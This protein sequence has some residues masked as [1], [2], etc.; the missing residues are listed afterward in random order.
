MD[1]NITVIVICCIV[2]KTAGIIPLMERAL[3]TSEAKNHI[4]WEMPTVA[5][6][7]MTI[8]KSYFWV[9]YKEPNSPS[10]LS[11][12]CSSTQEKS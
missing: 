11:N 9:S 4:T 5:P 8:L 7:I 6:M 10:C 3:S 12:F 1:D 2:P